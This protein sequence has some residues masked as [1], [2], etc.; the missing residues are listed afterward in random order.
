MLLLIL[1]HHNRFMMSNAF[2]K[3]RS[4]IQIRMQ[5]IHLRLYLVNIFAEVLTISALFSLHRID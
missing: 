3:Y 4:Q 2:R 5:S 1:Y